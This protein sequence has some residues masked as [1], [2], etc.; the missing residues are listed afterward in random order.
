MEN[1]NNE[2][3]MKKIF[4]NLNEDNKNTM[5]LIAKTIETV[6]KEGEK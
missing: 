6:Q 2:K 3:E 4:E 1:I 5:L